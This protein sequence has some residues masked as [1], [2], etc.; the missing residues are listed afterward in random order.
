MGPWRCSSAVQGLRA[1]WCA[2]G[3]DDAQAADTVLDEEPTID[4]YLLQL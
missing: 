4:R 1:R 3:M 2:S